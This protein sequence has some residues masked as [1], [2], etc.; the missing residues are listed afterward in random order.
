MWYN[1]VDLTMDLELQ[2]KYDL[3]VHKAL[4]L[5]LTADEA[6]RNAVREFSEYVERHKEVCVIDSVEHMDVCASR[7]TFLTSLQ[8]LLQSNLPEFPYRIRTPW[9]YSLPSPSESVLPTVLSAMSSACVAFPMM[10]KTV[11]S[12][13]SA[14]SHLMYVVF[15]EEGLRTA[16]SC[17]QEPLLIQEYINHDATVYKIYVFGKR[18]MVAARES[19]G[20]L[21]PVPDLHYVRFYTNQPWPAALKTLQT[22]IIRD[23]PAQAVAYLSDLMRTYFKISL[24]GYDVLRPAG[25]EDLVVIDLNYFPGYKEVKE[26]GE[27]MDELV[28]ETWGKFQG[29]K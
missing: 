13:T 6:S 27:M 11:D 8:T 5:Y 10:V 29:G 16:L 21:L 25:G 15:D 18:E 2:G 20:N 7:Q 19:S 1:A 22:P 17:Y 9:S 14:T 26:M 12:A 4:D 23:L 3:I 24:F 28:L